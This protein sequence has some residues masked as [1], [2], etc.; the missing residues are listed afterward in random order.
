MYCAGVWLTSNF[1]T[2]IPTAALIAIKRKKIYENQ[3]DKLQGARMTIETQVLTI[4]GTLTIQL[5]LTSFIF[6]LLEIF[7]GHLNCGVPEK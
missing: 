7:C 6:S 1:G 4:E 5:V 3:I 2:D